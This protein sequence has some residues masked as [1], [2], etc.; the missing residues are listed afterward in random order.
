ML[1]SNLCQYRKDDSRYKW[2]PGFAAREAG[3]HLRPVF[4]RE[5]GAEWEL[6]GSLAV[7]TERPRG[8]RQASSVEARKFREWGKNLA[9]LRTL[10]VAAGWRAADLRGARSLERRALPWRPTRRWTREQLPSRARLPRRGLHLSQ[11]LLEAWGAAP[12]QTEGAAVNTCFE[13]E[14][15][16]GWSRVPHRPRRLG[17]GCQGGAAR[18]GRGAGRE[19]LQGPPGRGPGAGE[20]ARLL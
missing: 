18:D 2:E 5:S 14:K 4:A 10:R 11:R 12:G 13:R 7:G 1:L 9:P 3:G 17:A 15:R 16:P 20:F 8:A 19:P 6:R